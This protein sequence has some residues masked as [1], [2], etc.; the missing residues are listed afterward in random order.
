MRL[1]LDEDAG[2]DA[3]VL[4]PDAKPDVHGPAEGTNNRSLVLRVRH[5]GVSMLL[6]GDI[7]E[8]V[9]ARLLR[10]GAI[11][12]SDVLKVGHHGSETSTSA[13]FLAAV[14]PSLAVISVGADNGFGHPAADVLSR[15]SDTTVRRTDLDGT[16]DVIS[17]GARVWVR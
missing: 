14:A 3:V 17:D 16:I 11:T 8:P 2:V 1:V 12:A 15:L 9:E 13:A 4:W 7:E 10:D 5:G 6:T